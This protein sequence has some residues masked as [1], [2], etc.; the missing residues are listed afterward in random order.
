MRLGGGVDGDGCDH[1]KWKGI[2][3]LDLSA[4]I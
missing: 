1:G 4:W 2:A 3:G